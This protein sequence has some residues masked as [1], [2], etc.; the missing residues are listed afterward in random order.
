VVCLRRHVRIIPGRGG[1][2]RPYQPCAFANK[3]PI[4]NLQLLRSK[5]RLRVP[6]ALC[7]RS[8][9]RRRCASEH[10]RIW[11]SGRRVR[12]TGVHRPLR[13]DHD[14][15][16]RGQNTDTSQL[17]AAA[18]SALTRGPGRLHRRS[19]HDDKS[20]CGD[21]SYLLSVGGGKKPGAAH[22]PAEKAL[23]VSNA[24]AITVPEPMEAN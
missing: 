3:A 6:A 12:H 7:R 11:M 18:S 4:G 14:G 8:T 23:S 10:N 9:E 22:L 19:R 17:V 15:T 16:E 5:P 1:H 2:H 13:A 20:P 21:P 24:P